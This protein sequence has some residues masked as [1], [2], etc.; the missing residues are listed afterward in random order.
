MEVD[1]MLELPQAD[2]RE[3]ETTVFALP[4]GTFRMFEDLQ[5]Y[6]ALFFAC[7]DQHRQNKP[8]TGLRLAEI[9]DLTNLDIKPIVRSLTYL[10]LKALVVQEELQFLLTLYGRGC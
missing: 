2:L 9:A 3:V 6:E 8:I 10:R 4:V 5:V 7:Y 1:S